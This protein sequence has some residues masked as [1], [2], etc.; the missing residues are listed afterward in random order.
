MSAWHGLSGGETRRDVRIIF[1]FMLLL[2]SSRSNQVEPHRTLDEV[3]LCSQDQHERW[4]GSDAK[5]KSPV[6]CSL[7]LKGRD[8]A[9]NQE[10]SAEGDGEHDEELS[11]VVTM[12]ELGDIQWF[13]KDA[14]CHSKANDRTSQ[15]QGDRRRAEDLEYRREHDDRLTNHNGGEPSVRV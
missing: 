3:E 7:L 2:V 8:D 15:S 11:S 14:K 4:D 13:E 6:S 5:E 1:L 10:A 12:G 9:D